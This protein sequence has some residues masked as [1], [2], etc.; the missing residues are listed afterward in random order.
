ML[1]AERRIGMPLR[2]LSAHRTKRFLLSL[3]TQVKWRR[4][5]CPRPWNAGSPA[6]RHAAAA[7]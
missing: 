4:R 3:P 5:S 6:F 1:W 7:I 2:W